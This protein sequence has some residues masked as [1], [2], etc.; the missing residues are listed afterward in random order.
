MSM[1]RRH[2]RTSG[3]PSSTAAPS[4]SLNPSRSVADSTASTALPT[5]RHAGSCDQTSHYGYSTADTSTPI[6]TPADHQT[7]IP[8]RREEAYPLQREMAETRRQ[9]HAHYF[10]EVRTPQAD[11][12]HLETPKPVLWTGF[13]QMASVPAIC[14][15]PSRMYVNDS[16]TAKSGI[17][18]RILGAFLP[19]HWRSTA[20]HN[21]K[22]GFTKQI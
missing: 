6:P 7:P 20:K 3:Y 4:D 11:N 16:T 13:L 15:Q 2:S 17:A 12:S 19:A 21:A 9:L 5:L 10:T 8:P 1:P 18:E 22:K 14:I